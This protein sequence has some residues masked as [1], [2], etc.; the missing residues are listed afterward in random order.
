MN[1]ASCRPQG[2][3]AKEASSP[4]QQISLGLVS[5]DVLHER[6]RLIRLDADTAP[7]DYVSRSD[8]GHGGE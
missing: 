2:D 8:V 7:N 1:S 4:K 6:A 5:H 3:I